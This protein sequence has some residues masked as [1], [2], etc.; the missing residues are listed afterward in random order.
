MPTLKELNK[1]VDKLNYKADTD[2]DSGKPTDN[3][4][5][6]RAMSCLNPPY[7]YVIVLFFV[8]LGGLYYTKPC[9]ILSKEVDPKTNTQKID[10]KSMGMYALGITVLISFGAHPY[11]MKK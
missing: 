7:V 3:S 11:V 5:K 2:T 6:A 8:V 9:Y 4:L 10:Y 1:E